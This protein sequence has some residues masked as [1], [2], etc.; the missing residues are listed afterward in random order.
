MSGAGRKYSKTAER[1]GDAADSA[2]GCREHTAGSKK[3]SKAGTANGSGSK[4]IKRTFGAS[5]ARGDG[6]K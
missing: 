1:S 5:S 3:R 4:F 2:R 6:G